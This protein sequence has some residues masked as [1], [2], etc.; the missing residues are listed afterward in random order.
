MPTKREARLNVRLPADL[1]RTIEEAAAQ[2]GQTV[3]DFAVSTLVR[4]A[5]QVV[6]DRQVTE[7]SQ[8]DWELFNSIVGDSSAEPNEALLAG[9]KRYK[10]RIRKRQTR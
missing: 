1:K 10:R 4:A 7:L 8:R 2:M 6:R 5:R 3:S 9:A